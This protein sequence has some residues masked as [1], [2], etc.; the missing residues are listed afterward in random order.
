MSIPHQSSFIIKKF[1]KIC[2]FRRAC[3]IY[4]FIRKLVLQFRFCF[5]PLLILQRQILHTN[6]QNSK[7]TRKPLYFHANLRYYHG[8]CRLLPDSIILPPSPY[9]QRHQKR[10]KKRPTNHSG[11]PLYAQNP[12][13]LSHSSILLPAS[14]QLRH[15]PLHSANCLRQFTSCRSRASPYASIRINAL[16]SKLSAAFILLSAHGSLL[17]S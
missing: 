15:A 16:A 10:K 17:L 9:S 11:E 8:N 3:R 12:L 6:G 4:C 5:S 1:L 7:Q 13:I 14:T 2:G